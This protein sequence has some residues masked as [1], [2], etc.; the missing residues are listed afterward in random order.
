MEQAIQL[1]PEQIKSLRQ[2]FLHYKKRNQ[3]IVSF[4]LLKT[5]LTLSLTMG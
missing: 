5:E 4:A 3:E 2:R 1:D